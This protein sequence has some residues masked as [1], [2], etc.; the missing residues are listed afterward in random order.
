M[1]LLFNTRN[2]RSYRKELHWYTRPHNLLTWGMVL[3]VPLAWVLPPLPLMAL[4]TG[5]FVGLLTWR[6][7]PEAQMAAIRQEVEAAPAASTS[8]Q[9]P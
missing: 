1:H 2:D 8:G 5:T 9:H 6:M 3:A 4:Y 7:S